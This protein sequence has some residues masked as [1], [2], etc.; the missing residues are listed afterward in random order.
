MQGLVAHRRVVWQTDER[1]GQAQG[2]C[3][4]EQERE[5]QNVGTEPGGK[6]GSL[7]TARPHLVKKT[8]I[9]KIQ[10]F[11]GRGTFTHLHFCSERASFAKKIT[12]GPTE[13]VNS[14][15]FL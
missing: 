4:R 11:V 5:K 1:E 15:A 7:N 2:G 12:T 10:V 13:L 9:S 3:W 14:I 8:Q 6:E